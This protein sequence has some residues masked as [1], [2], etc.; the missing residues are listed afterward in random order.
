M[1]A[2]PWPV[3]KRRTAALRAAAE[4]LAA[5]V[6]ADGIAA[7]T[8]ADLGVAIGDALSVA[9]IVAPGVPADL[10]AV[11]VDVVHAV[12]ADVDRAAPPAR[13]RPAP[14]RAHHRD[15]ARKGQAG[16]QRVAHAPGDGGRKE[17][18]RE[19][20]VRPG[21]EYDAGVVDRYVDALGI[22]R[23]D[24]DDL[25]RRRH[26]ARALRLHHLHILRDRHGLLRAAG[27][28][29]RRLRPPAQNLHGVEHILLLLEDGV[30]QLLRPF[31]LVVHHLQHVREGHERLHRG[32]PAL[33]LQRLRQRLALQ[34]CALGLSEPARRLDDLDRIGGRHQHL[35]Q[36]LVGEERDGREKLLELRLAEQ[37]GVRLH[38]PRRDRD[39][40]AGRH[41]RPGMR[42]KAAPAAEC[43][44]EQEQCRAGGAV[45]PPAHPW[46]VAPLGHFH[47]RQGGASR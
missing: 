39:T 33:R 44:G 45:P 41:L 13:P 27:Q 16:E 43:R 15:A 10:V 18:R 14:E 32:V 9:R 6:P 20:R 3:A 11:H 31:E 40:R 8:I 37:F 5:A 47:G 2:C 30:A 26:H 4:F 29:A 36:Q 7:D 46:H 25:G 35:R 17:N 42:R 28:R 19:A 24:D 12:R 23:R 34:R 21:A 22:G 1:D 38:R